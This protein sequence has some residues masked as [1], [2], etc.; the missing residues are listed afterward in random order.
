MIHKIWNIG[1]WEWI[2]LVSVPAQLVVRI[3]MEH[4]DKMVQ[5]K[6]IKGIRYWNVIILEVLYIGNF[7]NGAYNCIFVAAKKVHAM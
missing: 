1:T 3:K 4:R 6:K 5:K 7:K 2:K